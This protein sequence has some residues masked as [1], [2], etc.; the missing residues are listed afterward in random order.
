MKGLPGPT[1]TQLVIST[2]L[3][4]A[5]P[6]GGLL[7]F[8]LWN[9]P[10]MVFLTLCGIM[11]DAH[12]DPNNPPWYL[13]GLPPAAISLVFK[14]FYAFAVKLDSLGVILA[15]CSCLVA[16]LINNDKNISPQSS[17]W[18]FPL[19][20][21]L[22]ALV[23]LI[24]S[25]RAK[26]FSTY[27]SPSAGWDKESDETIKRIGIPLFVG[28]LVF[29]IWLGVLVLVILLVQ[30]ADI[31]NQYLEIFETMYRIG[32]I[33]FGGGQVVVS[34][35]DVDA[36]TRYTFFPSDGQMASVVALASRRSSSQLDDQGSVLARTGASTVHAR[37]I[38]QLFCVPRCG[39]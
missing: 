13:I 39:L 28:A 9:L 16:I 23:T 6:L 22:G 11:I 12:V 8:F 4:R 37:A 1:S 20:L 2:A 19:T 33:I 24:D 38:V 30:V 31:K 35:P 7:A 21:A 3:S 34:Y 36:V 18:V 15:L 32:S 10:G 27:K 29:L 25:K 17:Q 14:A 26:P 5:G